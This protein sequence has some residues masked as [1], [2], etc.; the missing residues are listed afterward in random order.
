MAKRRSEAIALRFPETCQIVSF[1]D[2]YTY[3]LRLAGGLMSLGLRPGDHLALL[4]ENRAEW[5][6][7]QGAAALMGAVLV[8]LN[9]HYRRHDLKF[10]LQQSRARAVVLSPRFRRNEYLAHVDALR[11]SLP[12]LEFV[13]LLDE[14]A[15]GCWSYSE[16]LETAPPERLP[17]VKAGDVASLQYTSGTTGFPKGALLTHEGMLK[18]AWATA[19]RLGLE[20]TDRW[21]SI[22][23]L[24]HC[25]GC[26]MN[27]LGCLQAGACYVGVSHFDPELMFQIIEGERCTVLTG[28]PTSYLAML[29]QPQRGR[30]DLSSLRTGTCGGADTDAEVLRRCAE[31]FPI[32]N[33]V[34]VYGQTES[35]TLIACPRFDDPKRFETAGEPLEGYEVRITDVASGEVLSAGET[36]QIEARG[37]MVMRGYFENE[38]ATAETITEDGWLKTGDLGFLD[39]E[40]RLVIAGGRLRDLI[41]RGGENIYPVE[42]E[43]RLRTHPRVLEVAVF[44]VKDRYYGEAVAA[45]VRLREPVE[46]SALAEHCTAAIA[47][48]KVPAK[49]YQ[50]DEFPMTSSGKVRKV[51]LQKLAEQGKLEAL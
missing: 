14:E 6:V 47:K 16:L 22:I 27:L 44:G 48:F 11:D 42:I 3:S 28:V 37:A 13:V 19:S 10:V 4:A 40:G 31:S 15:L 43:N 50:V 9:T 8:P 39:S 29:E 7:V 2:W 1:S 21:T 49:W 18:N 32:P 24:F 46:A 41:I 25:A 36:G 12:S 23:P 34:Q 45:A 33:V 26:I 20:S 51:A 35:S 17:E 30:Y 38:K 5:P